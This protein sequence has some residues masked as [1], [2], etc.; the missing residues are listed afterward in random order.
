VST[1][2]GDLV[3][4]IFREY[5]E[6]ADAVESYSYLTGAISTT[7][8]TTFN[9]E[10]DMFSS[11]EEDALGAGAIVEIGQELM[12]SKSLNVVT[13]EVTVQ[14]GARGT[15][16][17]THDAGSI[18]KITPAFA[19][20]NV[21][22]AVSDQIKN[23]YPTLFATETIELTASTGYKLL[24]TH[25][26]NVDNYN[27]LITPL[28]AISQYTDWQSGSDQTGLK[29]NGVAIEMIDL[30]NPFVYTDDTSTERTKTYTTGPDVVHAV[31]FA[32]ISAGHTVYVTFK[33][34]FIEPTNEN[35]TLASIGLETEYEPIVM[36]G[37]AAQMLVGKD[38]KQINASYI[39]DQISVQNAPV[40]SS[41]T[42][43]SSLLR[44]QQLLIQQARSNLRSKYPEPVQ[45]NSI[46][47]PT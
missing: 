38:I 15:T 39:T 13:N 45:L 24:G 6:P 3:D 43:S 36:A 23:L 5:L 9:Y 35:T 1:T 41:N 47:Y 12:F 34:K 19:R 10:E 11:E 14:R 30:P 29:Y 17:T 25:G 22:D 7:T 16:A 2:V 20:K 31:Q 18:V 42:I 21:Y 8:Q 32:G 33:K 4:R 26:S 28:K 37:A 46:L 27:Y 44:Y 40:G